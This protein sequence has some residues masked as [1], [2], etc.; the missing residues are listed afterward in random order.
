VIGHS[1]QINCSQR[2]ARSGRIRARER[3]VSTEG[4]LQ[5]AGDLFDPLRVRFHLG[6]DNPAAN[7]RRDETARK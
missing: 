7:A 1:H 4:L 3:V 6:H 5:Q 2:S